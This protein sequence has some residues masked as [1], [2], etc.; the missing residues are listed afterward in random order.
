MKLTENKAQQQAILAPTT[1]TVCLIAGAGT[2]KTETL[3]QRYVHVLN[4]HPELHPRNVVVLTFTDKAATEMRARIHYAVRAAGLPFTG[5][6]MA[7]AQISTFHAFAAKL[8][9]QRSIPLNLDP[10]MPFCD[11][12]EYTMLAEACW[13]EFLHD[14]WQRAFAQMDHQLQRYNW[15]DDAIRREVFGIIAD[16]KGLGY[17]AEHVRH[18]FSGDAPLSAKHALY[19]QMLIWNFSQRAQTLNMQGRLDLDEIIG[20][21]PTLIQHHPELRQHIRFVLVDE[22]QDT[23][24]AQA[25]LLQSITP[26]HGGRPHSRTVAGDPRQAIYVWRQANVQNIAEVNAYSDHSLYLRDNWR[27]TSPI[28]TVANLSLATYKFGNP[29]EFNPQEQLVAARNEADI[30]HDSVILTQY[31]SREQ[32]AEAVAHRIQE[33]HHKHG[34]AYADMAILLRRRTYIATYVAALEAANI[35]YDRGK[36]DPFFLRPEVRNMIH[37]IAAIANPAYEHS[38][39][40][41]V[42]QCLGILDEAALHS[43]RQQYPT[44][45]LWEAFDQAAPR[46]PAL[47]ALMELIAAAR[48]WQWQLSPTDWMLRVFHASG[49]WQQLSA[50]GQRLATKLVQEMHTTQPADVATL[51]ATM[52]FRLEHKSICLTPELI[53]NPDAVQL[54]TVHSA[55][56]LEYTAIFVVDAHAY[57]HKEEKQMTSHAG[58]IVDPQLTEL[59]HADITELARITYNEVQALWYVALTRAKRWLMVTA[60]QRKRNSTHTDCFDNLLLTL[61]ADSGKHGPG[62]VFAYDHAAATIPHTMRHDTTPAPTPPAG[63]PVV[64]QGKPIIQLSPSSLHE[65]VQCPKRFRYQRRSGFDA[66]MTTEPTPSSRPTLLPAHTMIV[67]INQLTTLTEPSETDAGEEVRPHDTQEAGHDARL[68][69]ILFHAA[70]ELHASHPGASADQLQHLALGSVDEPVPTAV[71]DLV[72]S[73]IAQYLHS[74]LGH[75]PPLPRD[76]EQRIIWNV[77]TSDAVIEL[78]GIIDRWHQGAIIDYKTDESVDGIAERH[79]DQLRLYALAVMQITGSTQPPALAVYHARSGKTVTIDHSES[80]LLQTR[81]HL[82]HAAR[83]IVNGEYP[84]RPQ[85]AYCA[86]CPALAH[87]AEGNGTRVQAAPAINNDDWFDW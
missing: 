75:T 79:G 86:H 76:V 46:I 16:L 70:C 72:A 85:P 22:Y 9:L 82:Q 4:A 5:L 55:K 49:Y 30:P 43:I 71:S 50:Y 2:G 54:M 78:S 42:H 44:C 12:T 65:I 68:I 83:H 61:Q 14:G 67:G 7:E 45:T 18:T 6:D 73:M 40:R 23:N 39:V 58:R 25:H 27:S 19:A 59:Q 81:Q 35:P 53:G 41:T 77:E 13:E 52:L 66:L 21:I 20:I 17:D 51:V 48:Q 29:P 37:L 11:E 64:L 74:H 3:S 1:A 26:H 15:N 57:T 34:V 28:L 80:A 63:A 36:D 24:T 32:E 84:A 62:I 33:L 47:Q 69:G 60:P 87:C 10:D 8:A 31:E 38:L 56:G